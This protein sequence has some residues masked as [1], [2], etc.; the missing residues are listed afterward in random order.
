MIAPERLAAAVAEATGVQAGV[1]GTRPLGGGDTCRALALELTD[2]RRFFVKHLEAGAA[3][4]GMFPAEHLALARMAEARAV[5]VP[6]PVAA[7][8]DFLV[9][10]LFAQGRPAADWQEQLGRGLAR[11]HERTR[12]SRFG[13]DQDNYCGLSPQPNGWHEDWTAFFRDRRLGPQLER[14]ARANPHD[15]MVHQ[16]Q[17]LLGAL[18]TIISEPREPAALLHGDLWSGN[19][20]ATADGSPIIFDPAAY[21]GRREAELGM[22]RLFGGF[23]PRCEAAYAETWPLAEGSE[24]RIAV[25]RLYHELNHL[26]LFG[27]AYYRRCRDTITAVL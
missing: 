16:G 1:A 14:F 6:A 23:G 12:Q 4:P 18:E 27:R 24:R 2:G 5:A 10:E 8:E 25:Y 3:R 22:M 21:Y 13:F 19:A 17:R 9:L 7:E 26:N 20:A 11:L 15:P